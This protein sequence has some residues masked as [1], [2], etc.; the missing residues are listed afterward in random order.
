M[1]I[2]LGQ[3]KSV[4]FIFCPLDYECLDLFRLFLRQT[5]NGSSRQ[6]LCPV[7][8]IYGIEPEDACEWILS[9]TYL[10]NFTERDSDGRPE[11]YPGR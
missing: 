9:D 7:D 2:L 4:V 11:D 1:L 5:G 8:Y 3:E 10:L 6:K